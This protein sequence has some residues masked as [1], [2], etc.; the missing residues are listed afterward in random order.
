LK[1]DAEQEALTMMFQGFLSSLDFSIQV[2]VHSRKINIDEYL[3]GIEERA[4]QETNELLRLHAEK[5][6]EYVRSLLEIAN[7]MEKKF[8]VAVPYD[9]VEVSAEAVK[10][11][12]AKLIKRQAPTLAPEVMTEEHFARYQAQLRVREEQVTAGL[13]RLG[14]PT[15]PLGTEELIEA[16][17]NLY[18]PSLQEKKALERFFYQ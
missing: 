4:A 13:G 14:I 5:Y 3:A 12:I 8:F 16:I 15:V 18:N 17:Y 7:I 1:S 11:G 6:I 2:A 10:G 9:P